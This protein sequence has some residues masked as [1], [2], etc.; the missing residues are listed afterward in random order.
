MT[1]A[2]RESP[3]WSARARSLVAAPPSPGNPVLLGDTLGA[4]ARGLGPAR[5][6]APPRLANRRFQAADHPPILFDSTPNAAGLFGA[7][8]ARARTRPATT[9]DPRR[10]TP[11]QL[12]SMSNERSG[13]ACA[14]TRPAD[15]PPRLDLARHRAQA[16]GR[17]Q[18]A[19]RC[20]AALHGIR[21]GLDGDLRGTGRAG[22]DGRRRWDQRGRT[23]WRGDGSPRRSSPPRDGAQSPP[24]RET[25][26]G[27][28]WSRPTR[29]LPLHAKRAAKVSPSILSVP[30]RAATYRDFRGFGFGAAGTPA[31]PVPTRRLP[32]PSREVGIIPPHSGKTSGGGCADAAQCRHGRRTSRGQW[33]AGAGAARMHRARAKS[34][35]AREWSASCRVRCGRSCVAVGCYILGGLRRG[36]W[37]RGRVLEDAASAAAADSSVFSTG[38]AARCARTLGLTVCGGGDG[39]GGRLFRGC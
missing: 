6:D 5:L 23:R 34:G 35:A 15:A 26:R 8:H 30:T 29:P 11:R 33:I 39:C 28:R 20:A 36:R 19:L 37:G 9:R 17:G 3:N 4:R 7:S 24:C 22:R 27:L 14:R 21:G 38:H 1:S 2:P 18:R 25:T 31:R 32:A 16:I 12:K 10:I 13:A